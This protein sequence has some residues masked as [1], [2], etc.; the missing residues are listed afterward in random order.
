MSETK[1][2]KVKFST[3]LPN[4]ACATFTHEGQRWFAYPQPKIQALG[5]AMSRTIGTVSRLRE[6]L[7]DWINAHPEDAAK[8]ARLLG[9]VANAQQLALEKAEAWTWRGETKSDDE[10]VQEV[11]GDEAG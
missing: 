7:V 11:Q 4:G 10:A 9:S 3:G 2:K 1:T 8:V 6:G 5:V